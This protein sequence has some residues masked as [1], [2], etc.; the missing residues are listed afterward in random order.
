MIDNIITGLSSWYSRWEN[1]PGLSVECMGGYRGVTG[2]TSHPLHE[3][4]KIKLSGKA[5]TYS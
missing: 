2:V 4:K 1:L 5:V 3:R